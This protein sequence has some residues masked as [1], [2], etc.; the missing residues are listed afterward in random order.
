MFGMMGLMTIVGLGL[1][2]LAWALQAYDASI[3][4]RAIQ[5]NFV[6]VYIT[7]TVL[8]AVS[9]LMTGV[10]IVTLL[11]CATALL[12]C[13]VL[14]RTGESRVT[15]VTRVVKAKVAKAKRK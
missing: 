3:G 14:L 4:K 7:G 11:N 5:K 8:I 10:G 9:S 13:L 12:A 15:T 6:L 1:I 2:V